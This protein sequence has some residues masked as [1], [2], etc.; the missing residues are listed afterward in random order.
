MSTRRISQAGDTIVEVLFA[1]TIFSLI[2]VGSISIM[3][4][5][6]AVAQRALEI[7]LVRQQIDAQADALRFLNSRYIADYGK[8]GQATEDW[9]KVVEENHVTSGQVQGFDDMVVD[10]KCTLPS[11]TSFALDLSKFSTPASAVLKPTTDTATYSQIRYSD[12]AARAEGIWVQAVKASASTSDGVG[13]YD[14]HI[15]ACWD[16]PGQDVPQTLGTIVRLYVPQA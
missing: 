8:N 6:L 5:G 1:V 16:S 2:A 10:K 4:Q 9:T 3:N 15:R 14:F 7:T 13:Y 12:T 11:N